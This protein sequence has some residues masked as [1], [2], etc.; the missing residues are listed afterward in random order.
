[1]RISIVSALIIFHLYSIAQE[2]VDLSFTGN[3]QNQPFESVLNTLESDV[4]IKFYYNPTWMDSLVF[5][6]SFDQTPIEEVLEKLIEGTDL[7]VHFQ[8]TRVIF[9]NKSPIITDLGITQFFDVNNTSGITEKGLVFTREYLGS[10]DTN[11]PEGKVYEIG[12]ISQ[13]KKGESVTI[14]GYVK[15]VETG[16]PVEGALVYIQEPLI[17]TPTDNEG[18]YSLTIPNGKQRILINSLNMKNTFRKVVL[19]SSGTLNIDLDVDV[20]AIIYNIM[21]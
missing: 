13:L 9:T 15:D 8:N 1:M 11:N 3:F 12:K 18:F 7:H 21:I 10:T 4:G 2:K 20:I 19:F 17:G 14:A 5:T 6:G 16:E